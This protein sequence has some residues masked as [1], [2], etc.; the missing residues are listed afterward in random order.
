[1]NNYKSSSQLKALA[2][3]QLMGKYANA[4]GIY[5]IYII[6][7]YTITEF[8]S[9][10]NALPTLF[11]GTSK[12]IFTILSY[13]IVLIIS[14][15][16]GLFVYGLNL[17]FLKTACGATA[18]IADIFGAF[19]ANFK[20]I[21]KV[22]TVKSLI[23]FLFFVPCYVFNE[24]INIQTNADFFGVYALLLGLGLLGQFIVMILYNQVFFIMLDFPS[25]NAKKALAFSRELMKGNKGRFIYLIV[26]FIPLYLLGICTC[27]VG[28][29]WVMPYMQ[30]TLA[31]FYL[32]LIQNKH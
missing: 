12:V 1:M 14:I 16:S 23:S 7:T 18:K 4:I 5:L 29:L 24:L 30:A 2:K 6:I 25:Y 3:E 27:C 10:F 31:Y 19:K 20:E 13:I 26:S 17:A 15:F 32:D 21:L 22:Q 28:L 9:I 8:S 11:S